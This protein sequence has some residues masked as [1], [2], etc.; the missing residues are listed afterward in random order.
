[1]LRRS[2]LFALIAAFAAIWMVGGWFAAG[3]L[4]REISFE[5]EPGESLIQV[6]EHLD[7]VGAVDNATIF[8]IRARLLGSADP[9][10]AGRFILPKGASER[11][12][13]DIV[14]GGKI[15]RRFVTIPEGMPSIMVRDRLM[16]MPGL[17][18]EIPV[19]K[20][21]SI[22]PDTYEI[23]PG[24][25]RAAVISRMQAA[26]DLTLA[27]L[28]AER[29]ATTYVKTPEEAVNLAAI[30][31]KE[32]GKAEERH[33]V[34]GLYTNRLRIGMRLQADP[35]VIYPITKGKPLG[36]RIRKSELRDDNG[37]N[38][39]A[40][41]GLPKGPI[42]NP[43]KASIEAVLNPA[44]TDYIYFVADG[45]GGHVFARTLSEHNANV[46]RWYALRRARGEM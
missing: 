46:A 13:L 42:T 5:V 39:Y 8:R 4:D 24:E 40:R 6:A 36:R 16:A 10:Q 11:A 31:E 21:G 43:G 19:P 32:T 14:Q 35:T 20:E 9:I 2:T 30:V 38:T 33:Q 41:A 22:L 15:V 37:Y 27:E 28:W 26:M 29:S 18:G 23:S 12:L 1:M 45:T 7:R 25:S 44:K 3:P 17:T 34:A